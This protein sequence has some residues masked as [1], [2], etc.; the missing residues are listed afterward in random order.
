[1][2]DDNEKLL[3]QKNLLEKEVRKAKLQ[4]EDLTNKLIG[5]QEKLK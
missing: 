2:E 3:R 1:M 4:N 5:T